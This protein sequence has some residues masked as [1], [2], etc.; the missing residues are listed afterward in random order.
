MNAVVLSE[1]EVISL[2]SD[3]TPPNEECTSECTDCHCVDGDCCR[4]S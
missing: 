3:C 1:I 4:D 2:V